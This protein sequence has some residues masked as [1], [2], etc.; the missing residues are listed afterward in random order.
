MP[1]IDRRSS[2]VAA[3][4]GELG[5]GAGDAV[6]LLARNSAAFI[7]AQVAISKLGADVLYVNTGFA[8]PQLGEVL[9]SENAAA[10]IADD[11]FAPLLDEVAGVAAAADRVGRGRRRA[12]RASIAG[13]V[14]RRRRPVRC[15]RCRHRATRVGTSS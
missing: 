5:I 13:L 15:R 2:I 10:V 7:V 6:A 12:G 9:R 11:E 8:G 1:S 14:A 4:L 3:A